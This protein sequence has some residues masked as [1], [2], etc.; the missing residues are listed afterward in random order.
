[1][2]PIKNPL[3]IPSH[4]GKAFRIR[5]GY[6]YFRWFL[7]SLLFLAAL[8]VPIFLIT[9][10]HPYPNINA[11]LIS[12][13]IAGLLWIAILVDVGPL[14]SFI[15]LNEHDF[16]LK[17]FG[18]KA[19]RHKYSTILV[20]NERPNSSKMES[21]TELTVYL[22][23]NWFIIRS[24]DFESYDYLKTCLTQYGQSGARQKV[25]TL[26]ERNRF[27]RAIGGVA[28]LILANIAFGYLA[29]NPTD[30]N[31]ARLI[32]LTNQAEQI[33][34]NRNKGKLTGL[35][36][37]IDAFPNFSFSVSQRGYDTSLADAASALVVRQPITL[38]IRESDYRKKLRQS[39]PLTFGDK[40]SGQFN[41]IEV[42]GIRQ[43]NAVGLSASAPALEPTR[44]TPRQRTFLLG[45]LLLM[46]W[47]GW[48]YVE[49]HR[50]LRANS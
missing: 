38:L 18:Q 8:V 37:L 22:S 42:F 33:K 41:Q 34:E 14:A 9:Q 11:I 46:C 27:R 50:V 20:H 48:V 45:F 32:A 10:V 36:L 47:A 21:F 12:W 3:T 7:L 19:S 23:D 40:Y 16:T 49:Q 15:E 2:N 44:T 26:T 43:G 4:Q 1:M 31:P 29:H 13:S 30:P 28:V 39:E 25:L 35:T 6:T 24:N 5:N 17:K